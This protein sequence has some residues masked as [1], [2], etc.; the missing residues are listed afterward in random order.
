MPGLNLT[1]RQAQRLWSLDEETCREVMS[2]LVQEGFL[3]RTGDGLFSRT[4]DVDLLG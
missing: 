4:E 3:H 2:E 1:S